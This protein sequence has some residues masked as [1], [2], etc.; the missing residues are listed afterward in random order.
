MSG[1]SQEDCVRGHER[2]RQKGAQEKGCTDQEQFEA[3]RGRVF[4]GFS[5]RRDHRDRRGQG[6]GQLELPCFVG[7]GIRRFAF[8]RYLD[9]RYWR[10]EG[11]GELEL[12]CSARVGI[13]GVAFHRCLDHRYWLGEG[14]GQHGLPCSCGFGRGLLHGAQ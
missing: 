11:Q 1:E 7:F 3:C 6:Q 14:Q 5:E 10:G 2:G 13:R 4:G 9:H 8:H 12:I